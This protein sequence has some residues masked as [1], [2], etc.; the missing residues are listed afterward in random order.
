MVLTQLNFRIFESRGW[1]YAD[2]IVGLI[3]L[4]NSQLC[5]SVKVINGH[6]IMM[7][8]AFPHCPSGPLVCSNKPDVIGEQAYP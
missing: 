1:G 2:V 3:D 4:S 5:L 7:I 8:L 6:L